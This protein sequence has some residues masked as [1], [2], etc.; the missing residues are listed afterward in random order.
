MWPSASCVTWLRTGACGR[1]AVE[2]DHRPAGLLDEALPGGGVPLRGL[3]E[4][5]VDVGLTLGD[6]A[7]L[8][9]ASDPHHPV[10]A[11]RGDEPIGAPVTPRAAGRDRRRPC[12]GP[13]AAAL[14]NG[15]GSDNAPFA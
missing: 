15:R 4:A 12:P 5:R 1:R 10:G 9:G 7:G 11:E 14:P 2:G 3:S 8:D 13:P 6:Q